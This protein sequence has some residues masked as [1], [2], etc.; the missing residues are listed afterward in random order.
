VI[1]FDPEREESEGSIFEKKSL[2]CAAKVIWCFKNGKP[3]LTMKLIPLKD[4][5]HFDSSTREKDSLGNQ[6]PKIQLLRTISIKQE[7][8]ETSGE[9]RTPRNEK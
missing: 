7:G 3:Q 1:R 5:V 6:P 4:R 9:E 8:L 2:S